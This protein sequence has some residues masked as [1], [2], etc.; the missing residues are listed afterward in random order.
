MA[1]TPWVSLSVLLVLASCAV[2]PNFHRP[3]PPQ[4][5]GYT[6]SPLT[7]AVGTTNISGGEPQHFV[8]GLD[9]S[10]EWW[11]L[12]RSKPLNALI[13]RS[14]SNNPSIKAAQAALV[15]A[16]E[17]VKAQNGAYYPTVSGSFSASRQS[18]ST[19]IAP[20]P[21]ANQF[22]YSLFT[23]Q[24]AISYVPDVF[25]FNR[26][27][28]ESLKAQEEQNRFALAATHITLSANVVAAAIQEA[29]LRGEISATREL[30]AINTNMLQISRTQFARGYISRLDVAAQEAQLAAVAATLPPLLKQLAQQRDL[31]AVLAGAFPTDGPA[32]QFELSGLRLP[33]GD[34]GE[35]ALAARGPTAGHPPGRGE[36]ARRQRPDRRGHRQ[37]PSQYHP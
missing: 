14:L 36:P 28:V 24:L 10:G 1:A 7:N 30:I 13:E 37:P 11:T 27:T 35:P 12:F 33:R 21:N 8:E 17:T 19:L 6:A 16:R 23:P 29:A 5:K 15:V 20:V 4:V 22:T 32:E 2:G 9:I 34:P 31:L 25:G 3:P 18:Q 26:R